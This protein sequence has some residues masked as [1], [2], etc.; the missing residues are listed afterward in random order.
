MRATRCRWYYALWLPFAVSTC[1]YSL[2]TYTAQV[3]APARSYSQAPVMVAIPTPQLPERDG[4]VSVTDLQT[5]EVAPSTSCPRDNDRTEVTWIVRDLKQGASRRY[6]L[7]WAE[8]APLADD[9]RVALK[10]LDGRDEAGAVEIAIDGQLFTRYIYRGAPKPYCYPIIGPTGAPVTRGY[11]ME[12]IPGE[13]HDHHHH[14]SFWFTFGEVNGHDFWAESDTT[15]HQVHRAFEALSSGGACGVLRAVNDWTASDGTKVCEDVRELRVYG[16]ADVRLLD[17]SVTIRATDG[18]VEF[19]DTK[20]G[21]FGFRVASTMRLKGGEGT[22]A[23]AEGDRDGETWGKRAAWCDYAGPVGGDTVGIAIFDHPDNFR[24]PTY[25]HVRDYGLFAANPFGLRHFVGDKTGA[26]R[27]T[28]PLGE[29]LTFRYRVLIHPGTCEEAR[30]ADWYA[31]YAS[32]PEVE[33]H[34]DG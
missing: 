22:I 16:I 2:P 26:G 17:F 27:Y 20:E 33:V 13:S 8:E 25:W 15:G 10:D 30:V 28:L 4:L 11:P 9:S 23:N 21:M 31:E 29:E 32:P 34:A 12:E 7:A 18:P 14:R 5:S 19:G 3:S 24:Y 6:R 1:A